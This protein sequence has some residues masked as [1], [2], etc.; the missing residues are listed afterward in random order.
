GAPEPGRNLAGALGGA[1]PDP[2]EVELGSAPSAPLSRALPSPARR[3][4]ERALPVRRRRRQRARGGPS[5]ARV[6]R[7]QHGGELPLR[8]RRR[9]SRRGAGEPRARPVRA[10]RPSASLGRAAALAPG[11]A[12]APRDQSPGG[13]GDGAGRAQP[14]ARSAGARPVTLLYAEVPRF[15]AEVERA[16][17]PALAERPVIVGG[18]PRK[19]GL[20]QS[21]TLDALALGVEVGMP[22]LGALDRCPGAGGRRP[23]LRSSR[24]VAA[25]AGGGQGGH[26]V[27]G[28]AGALPGRARAA[29]RSPFLPRARR[30]PARLLPARLA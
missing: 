9:G 30:A 10:P 13:R 17:D 1:R 25:R 2:R 14:R 20:V 7:C 15:Y 16:A 5:P 4:G 11:P 21:A 28:A 3:G 29:H 23:D 18:D 27:P 6:L 26:A 22:I 24:V 12:L 8:D 19:R